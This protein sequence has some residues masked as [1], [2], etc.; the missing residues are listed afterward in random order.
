MFRSI[1]ASPTADDEIQRHRKKQRNRTKILY[2][3]KYKKDERQR[4]RKRVL[5]LYKNNFETSSV[6]FL[7]IFKCFSFYVYILYIQHIYLV[8]TKI[9][10]SYNFL[11]P[12]FI[13]IYFFRFLNR[14]LFNDFHLKT[15]RQFW[16]IYNIS[17]VLRRINNFFRLLFHFGGLFSTLFYLLLFFHEQ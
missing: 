10:C 6:T 2:E 17:Q 15:L 4:R 7:G 8:Y 5:K 9:F 1:S 14:K 11:F 13:T 12:F 3:N 16:K